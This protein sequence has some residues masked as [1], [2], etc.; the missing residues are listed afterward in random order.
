M[1]KTLTTIVAAA[2]LAASASAGQQAVGEGCDVEGLRQKIAAGDKIVRIDLATCLMGSKAKGDQAEARLLFKTVMDEG[3]AEAKNGYAIMLL[4]GVG[5]PGDRV[6]GQK[7]QEEAAAQGSYGAQLTLAEHYLRGGGFYPKDDAKGLALLTQVADSGKVRGASKG[8]IEWRIGMMYL[9]GRGT[10]KDDERAYIWV[11]RG[12]ES[13]SEDA[14]IS[15][16]VMLATGEGVAEDDGAARSWYQKAIDMKGKLLAHA[17]RG[18]GFMIWTGEGGPADIDTA[19]TYVYAAL[20]GGDENARVLLEDKGWEKQ[21]SKKQRKACE[22]SADQWI[23]DN[24]GV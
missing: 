18:L 16:A 14:M 17:L 19:C 3:D 13:G 9:G 20:R 1:F 22:Q 2:T 8:W 12:S 21:L 15:R 24:L 23:K 11:V 4:D 10:Q 6:A 5:G 7:L